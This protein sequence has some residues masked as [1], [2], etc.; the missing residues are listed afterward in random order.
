MSADCTPLPPLAAEVARL[1]ALTDDE[2]V[3][4]SDARFRRRLGYAEDTEALMPVTWSEMATWTP[5]RARRLAWFKQ[6]V[7]TCTACD[8]YPMDPDDTRYC[9]DMEH[10]FA[11]RA[12]A[13]EPAPA[14]AAGSAGR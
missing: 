1:E 11:D 3:A 13:T 12:F 9:A 8:L 10:F 4:D 6:H 5:E 2:I 14:P 7:T